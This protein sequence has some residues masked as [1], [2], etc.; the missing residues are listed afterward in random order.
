VKRLFSAALLLTL[1]GLAVILME[2]AR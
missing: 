1:L 2:A